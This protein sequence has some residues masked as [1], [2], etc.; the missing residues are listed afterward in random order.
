MKNGLGW[1]TREKQEFFLRK[2]RYTRMIRGLGVNP[3]D[4]R[5]LRQFGCD[6]ESVPVQFELEVWT[7]ACWSDLAIC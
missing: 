4:R 3:G 6:Q 2:I 7:I 5:G 1:M